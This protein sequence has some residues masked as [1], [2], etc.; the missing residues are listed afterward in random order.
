MV[1]ASNAAVVDVAVC[2][3]ESL[4]VHTTDPPTGTRTS[5]GPNLKPAIPTRLPSAVG[6]VEVIDVM[7]VT[8]AVVV[9]DVLEVSLE[10]APMI[11]K[12]SAS[13]ADRY[14]ID[15]ASERVAGR[16]GAITEM[17]IAP[18]DAGHLG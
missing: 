13:S 16:I 6:V 4:L 1:P 15:H 7:E 8:T 2:C 10:Q 5:A 9:V 11:G 17:A 18:R 3:C 12:A 14:L